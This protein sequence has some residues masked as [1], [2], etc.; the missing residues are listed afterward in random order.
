MD[1]R[2]TDIHVRTYPALANIAANYARTYVGEFEPML[3]ARALLEMTGSLPVPISRMVLNVMRCDP[4]VAHT[5]PNLVPMLSLVSANEPSGEAFERAEFARKARGQWEKAH[6]KKD[7]K[8]KKAK[9]KAAPVAPTPRP[10]HPFN[11]R[12]TWKREH[13]ASVHKQA[14]SSH[15]LNPVKSEIR[16]YPYDGVYK[17]HLR[18]YC[19]VSLTF[20]VLLDERP[21]GRTECRACNQQK[22]MYINA[23][24][25]NAERM[26]QFQK[27]SAA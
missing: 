26:E 19:G 4:H 8:N 13:Y 10:R 12:V 23:A 16:Y 2:Y 17:P 1:T 22:Q 5:L 7:K 27:G 9:R 25:E 18:A 11:L 3:G 21:E 6:T 14:T 24:R 20:G 15:L